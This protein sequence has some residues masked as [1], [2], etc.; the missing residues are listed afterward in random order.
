MFDNSQLR[1]KL[2]E[3]TGRQ[4]ILDLLVDGE[5]QTPSA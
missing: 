4:A 2:R 5:D 1:G 3:A